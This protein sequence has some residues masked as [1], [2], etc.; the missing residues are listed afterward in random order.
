MAI[1]AGF[2]T[3]FVYLVLKAFGDWSASWAVLSGDETLGPLWRSLQLAAIE[4]NATAAFGL[5]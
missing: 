2:A 5:P 4:E 3:P 1:T